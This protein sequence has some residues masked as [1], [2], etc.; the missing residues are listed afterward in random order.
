MYRSVVAVALGS[1]LLL[2][3]CSS[4]EGADGAGDTELAISEVSF[5]A[6]PPK[7]DVIGQA[8]K[9]ELGLDVKLNAVGSSDD[10]YAQLSASLAGGDAPDLFQVDRSRLQQFVKQGLVLDLTKYLD[11][12]LKQYT[13]FVGKD[14]M[15]AA[16]LDG[17]TYGVVKRPQY[18]YSTYWIRKDWLDKLGL[19]VPKTTDDLFAVATAFTGKDPDGNGKPDTYGITGGK[20]ADPWAPLWG[21]FGTGGPGAEYVEDGKIVNGY[22]DPDTKTA[23]EYVAKLVN[24]KVVDPDFLS[25]TLAQAQER[26]M[27]GK[28]GI[29]CQSW[30]QMT[31]PEFTASAKKAQPGAQWIQLPPLA[32]PAGPGAMPYD[33]NFASI[34]AIPAKVGKDEAKLKNIMKFVEYISGQSGNRLVSYG[35]EGTHYTVA[36]GKVKATPK[37]ATDGGWF[38]LY[39]LTGRDEG[40]YLGI[41]FAAQKKYIDF[42]AKQ[43]LM[44]TYQSLVVNPDGYNQVDA[45]RYS[46]EQ[47]VQFISGKKP[48]SQYDAFVSDLTNKFGYGKYVEGAQQQ[49]TDLGL[50]K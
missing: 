9:K 27:Q 13:S 37:L 31:K 21:G 15:K 3:A 4:G 18:P 46:N 5:G 39:Q 35:I 30:P 48:L 19:A 42:A 22:Q 32:G 12:D 16:I 50:A 11:T 20:D 28:A 14:Q 1:A 10:Y 7:D 41:K 25:S 38:W 34:Y 43:P 17:K 40:E 23:L 49:L 45:D 2:T 36:D 47:L 26:A 44:D 6:V 29:L 33:E 8:L 24:A